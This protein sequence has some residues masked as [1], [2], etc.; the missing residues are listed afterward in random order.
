MWEVKN[1]NK[2]TVFSVHTQKKYITTKI[3]KVVGEVNDSII[4]D[5]MKFPG[6][7]INDSIQLDWYSDPVT[8]SYQAHKATQGHLKIEFYIP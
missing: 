1:I 3:L 7:K 2:D 5:G 8:V 4:I 6:G